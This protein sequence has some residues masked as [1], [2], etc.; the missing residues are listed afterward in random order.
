M[1]SVFVRIASFDCPIPN[2]I[3]LENQ[4]VPNKDTIVEKIRSTYYGK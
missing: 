2:G 3:I 1:G 4:V